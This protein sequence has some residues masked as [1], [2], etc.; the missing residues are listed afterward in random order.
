MN[1]QI[2]NATID[3][4]TTRS[5]VKTVSVDVKHVSAWHHTLG[6]LTLYL[7]SAVMTTDDESCEKL[8][9]FL[10]AK[11]ASND[12]SLVVEET[13]RQLA[14]ATLGDVL[15][16]AGHEGDVEDSEGVPLG[17]VVEGALSQQRDEYA[18]VYASRDA[19]ED[20][21]SEFGESGFDYTRVDDEVGGR[22]V[23]YHVERGRSE[24]FLG[25]CERQ[26]ERDL[27]LVR[28]ARQRLSLDSPAL[29]RHLRKDGALDALEVA[30]YARVEGVELDRGELAIEAR[31]DLADVV[32][33]WIATF[34]APIGF[35]LFT[36]VGDLEQRRA[37][38]VAVERHVATGWIASEG[39]FGFPLVVGCR[40]EDSADVFSLVESFGK[41]SRV[42]TES[43]VEDAAARARREREA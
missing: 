36:F 8:R 32:R 38:T 26:R 37:L 43:E 15:D 28:A 1:I 29:A 2:E 27:Q 42:L 25:I 40:R 23:V 34:I 30:A 21:V 17:D 12:K 10:N 41:G 39:G 20:A 11:R 31:R 7:P 33:M 19:L 14:F 35:E 22:R 4:S 9:A 16:L 5:I 18:L 6:V 13:V 24:E 3:T